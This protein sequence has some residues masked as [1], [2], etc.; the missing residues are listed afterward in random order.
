MLSPNV[1]E[2][3]PVQQC[4]KEVALLRKHTNL[5][6]FHVFSFDLRFFSLV[7]TWS[8]MWLC[9]C[10]CVYVYLL[11]YSLGSNLYP[12]VTK[13]LTKSPKSSL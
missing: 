9:G 3:F 11:S 12:E 4:M 5:Q 8:A 10:V 2:S 13:N 6:L 7:N 1:A